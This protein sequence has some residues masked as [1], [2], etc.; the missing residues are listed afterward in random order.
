MSNCLGMNACV[1]VCVCEIAT[2]DNVVVFVDV[3]PTVEFTKFTN[4][5]LGE[6]LLVIRSGANGCIPQ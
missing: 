5:S 2:V 4:A 1:P 6:V 3:N